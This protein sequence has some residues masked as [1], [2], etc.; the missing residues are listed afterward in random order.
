VTRD[1]AAPPAV[2]AILRTSCYDCHSNET[3]WPLYGSIAPVS[4]LV[5][6]DV[7]NG[8][9]A[10]NF[11]RWDTYTK[12]KR[13]TLRGRCYALAAASLMPPPDYRMMHRDARLDSVKLAALRQW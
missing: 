7:K 2:A 6:T 10:M 4:W 5:A 9:A 1:A 11:S 12:E 13:D 8:R 3:R